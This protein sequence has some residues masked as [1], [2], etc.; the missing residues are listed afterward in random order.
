MRL[1]SIEKG[2]FIYQQGEDAHSFFILL[3]G[4]MQVDYLQLDGIQTVFSFISPLSTLGDLELFKEKPAIRNVQAVEDCVLMVAPLHLAKELGLEHSPFLQF[5][6]RQ[7]IK[8]LDHSST[9]LTQ[10]TL[11]LERRLASYLLERMNL[12]GRLF[13]LENRDSLSAMLA[14]STRHL[15]RTLRRLANLNSIQFN[16]KTIQI[17]AP[18]ILSQI[19]DQTHKGT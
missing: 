4:K 18:D 19:V 8:K 7:I 3:E 12:E 2:E 16:H 11:P 13:R 10:H 17:I 5:L 6:I 1:I 15:N 9:L 14:T